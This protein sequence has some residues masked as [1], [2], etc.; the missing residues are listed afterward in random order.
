MQLLQ[1]YATQIRA[2]H[3]LIHSVQLYSKTPPYS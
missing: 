1:I 2:Y 3:W